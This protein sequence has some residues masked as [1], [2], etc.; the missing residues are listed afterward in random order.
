[1]LIKDSKHNRGFRKIG[2]AEQL[3]KRKDGIVKA[4]K[5]RVGKLSMERAIQHF[6]PLELSCVRKA[7]ENEQQNVDSTEHE[8]RTEQLKE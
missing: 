3:I 6:Y 1:M 7:I 4:V 2:I 5:L 8:D